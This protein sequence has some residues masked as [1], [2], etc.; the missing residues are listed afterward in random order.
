MTKAD[1]TV[2]LKE[3]TKIEL[4]SIKMIP[5]EPYDAVV[6]RLIKFFYEHKGLNLQDSP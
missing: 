1:K 6:Q 5:R 2:V 4:D 3:K